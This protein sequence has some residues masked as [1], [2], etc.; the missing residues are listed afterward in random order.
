MSRYE[1]T[2]ADFEAVMSFNPSSH[3][4]QNLPVENVSWF[5]ACL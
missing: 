4:G 3:K 1:V 5:N 2:Q